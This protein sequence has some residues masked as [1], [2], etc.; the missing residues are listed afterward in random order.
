MKKLFLIAL[1]FLSAWAIAQQVEPVRY[2]VD[3]WSKDQDC[4]FQT[5]GPADGIMVY[6]TERTNKEKQQRLWR[7][8]LSESK[9]LSFS[10]KGM[11]SL[12]VS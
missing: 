7:P 11:R 3:R 9:Y 1:L 4:H 6:E 10:G 2:E 5:V 8:S 12:R